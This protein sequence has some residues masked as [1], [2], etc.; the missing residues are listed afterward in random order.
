MRIKHLIN[1]EY[2]IYIR[3]RYGRKVNIKKAIGFK[4]KPDNW[5][6]EKKLVAFKNIVW[7]SAT[8]RVDFLLPYILNPECQIILL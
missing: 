5:N 8:Q 2:Y 1:K 6:N 7:L 3:Y 4:I